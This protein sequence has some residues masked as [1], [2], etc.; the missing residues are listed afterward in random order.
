MLTRVRSL[1]ARLSLLLAAGVT[2]MWLVGGIVAA[3]EVH[4]EME[5]VFD[6]ALQETAQRILPLAAIDIEGRDDEDD[7][8]RR[9]PVLGA[10]DEYLTYVVRDA[11][12]TILLKSHHADLEIFRNGRTTG[13]HSTLFY[14]F[15]AETTANGE[16]RI[17]VAEPLEHRRETTLEALGALLGPLL[18]LVPVSI[19]VVWW[20]VRLSLR[21]VKSLSRQIE[22]RGS[23]NLSALQL[24]ETPKELEPVVDAVNRLLERLG[25]TLDAERS[26]TANSA[27]EIR[28]PIAA[29]LAQTQRLIAELD[30]APA[31]ERAKSVER[32][33]KDLSRLSEKLLQLAKAEGGGLL[34]ENAQDLMPVLRHVLDELRLATRAGSDAVQMI[35]PP[36]TLMTSLD[37]DAFAILVR[38]VVENALKYGDPATPVD[39]LFPAS[40]TLRI[41]NAG[42]VLSEDV[43]ARVLNRFERGA[44]NTRG[45][46]LG[47]AIADTIMRGAAGELRLLSPAPGLADGVAV[48]VSLPA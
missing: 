23:G 27:H 44:T 11:S 16:L 15:Y 41:V 5:D 32:A 30:D 10:H 28:T 48:D 21:P 24:P 2:V 45:S 43:R 25:R 36:D 20:L 19:L 3:F 18:L 4:H 34:Q 12:G 42:E 29:A 6:S 37:P 9:V 31:A 26:F 7:E 46:G 38:N 22:A 40:H 13:F 8:P 1:Q 39:V 17:E 33:L 35:D 47:L 14:R